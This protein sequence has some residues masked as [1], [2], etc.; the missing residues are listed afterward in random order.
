MKSRS[1]PIKRDEKKK[2]NKKRSSN[3]RKQKRKR[4]EEKGRCSGKV[5]GV[6]GLG[7]AVDERII[8]RSHNRRIGFF[9]SDL[10]CSRMIVRALSGRRGIG[11]KS[12]P[13]QRSELPRAILEVDGWWNAARGAGG[14]REQLR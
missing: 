6:R 11:E 12:G 1:S 9:A 7:F 4:E 14:G 10:H 2:K 3:E 8:A 13:Y 5:W